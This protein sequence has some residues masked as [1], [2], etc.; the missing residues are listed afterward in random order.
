MY[1][2]SLNYSVSILHTKDRPA[3]A[4][5][6]MPVM[7][8]RAFAISSSGR[9]TRFISPPRAETFSTTSS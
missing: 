2:W 8:Y 7:A 1:I 4:G 3:V 6:L 9:V 5:R